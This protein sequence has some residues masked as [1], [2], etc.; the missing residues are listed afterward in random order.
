MVLES[1]NGGVR[2]GKKDPRSRVHH[3]RRFGRTHDVDRRPQMYGVHHP[4]YENRSGRGQVM[5]SLH[6]QLHRRGAVFGSSVNGWERPQFFRNRPAEDPTTL[7]QPETLSFDAHQCEWTTYAEREAYACRNGVA[8]FDMSSFGKLIVSGKDA[9][10]ALNW[11]TSSHVPQCGTVQY[12]QCLNRR[13]GVESDVTVLRDP[14]RRD[15]R[16]S[17]YVVTP[18]STVLRDAEHLLRA[19]HEAKIRDFRVRNVTRDYAVLAVAGPEAARVVA[20]LLV[21]SDREAMETN[22][23]AF[24]SVRA[25][26][27]RTRVNGVSAAKIAALRVSYAGE[28]GIELHTERADAPALYDALH[29]AAMELNCNDG[30]GL[31]DGGLR[32]L[33]QSLRVEKGFVHFGH[34]CDPT[35]TQLESGLGFVSASKIKDGVP[36]LGRE[37]LVEQ[38]CGPLQQRLVSIKVDDEMP[39]TLWGH[40]GIYENGRRIGYVTSGGIGWATNDGNAIGLGLVRSKSGVSKKF[41]REGSFQ[42]AVADARGNLHLADV[43]LS[44]GP[45]YDPAGVRMREF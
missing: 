38:K 35:I 28:W 34:D 29:R 33:L 41:L 7:Y 15:S 39:V 16:D 25:L 11:C 45:L 5:S 36:F 44:I 4:N 30:V 17:F 10:A 40:E 22:T 31:I 42:V 18:S 2:R 1:R 43:A 26:D 9:E 20:N 21:G 6:E 19:S 3:R 37:P 24:G 8:L 14:F 12:T 23:F 27:F 13:G 32:A